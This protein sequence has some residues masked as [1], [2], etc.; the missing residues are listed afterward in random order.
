MLIIYQTVPSYISSSSYWSARWLSS[1]EKVSSSDLRWHGSLIRWLSAP[2]AHLLEQT[3]YD[4][5]LYSYTHINMDP[6]MVSPNWA[7]TWSPRRKKQTN[8]HHMFSEDPSSRCLAPAVL[9]CARLYQSAVRG[10]HYDVLCHLTR[11]GVMTRLD[12]MRLGN[13]FSAS[14]WGGPS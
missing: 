1:D 14:S 3:S 13:L 10:C 7:W 5:Y 12:L 11:E 4:M 6:S 2:A 8:S 9:V